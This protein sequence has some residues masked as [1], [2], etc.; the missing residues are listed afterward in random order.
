[1]KAGFRLGKQIFFQSLSITSE[2]RSGSVN[3]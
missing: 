3:P 1:M 2:E